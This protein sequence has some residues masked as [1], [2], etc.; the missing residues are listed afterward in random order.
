MFRVRSMPM[1]KAKTF[2]GEEKALSVV[3]CFT[4]GPAHESRVREVLTGEVGRHIA[5]ADN[6]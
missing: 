1:G 3:L 5:D 6:Y 2:A 4:Q